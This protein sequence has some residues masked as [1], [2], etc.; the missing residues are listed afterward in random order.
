M[1]PIEAAA[2][3]RLQHFPEAG[4]NARHPQGQDNGDEDGK[5]TER[6]HGDRIR[7][8]KGVAYEK[9]IQLVL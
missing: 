7:L 4:E 1:D 5:I 8:L 2:R 9:L 6:V 3:T